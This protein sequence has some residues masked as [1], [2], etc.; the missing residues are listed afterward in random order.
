M[1]YGMEKKPNH[2]IKAEALYKQLTTNRQPY[3]DRARDASLV[4][5]P[6]LYPPEGTNYSTTHPTPYQSLG[7]KGVNNMANKNVQTLFPPS[8]AFFKLGIGKKKQA[9]LQKSEGDIKTAMYTLESSIV[10]D[11]ETSGLRPKLVHALK[12]LIVGGNV[13][14]YVPKKGR[15]EVFRLDEFG[16][17]RDKQGNVLRLAIQQKVAYQSLSKKVQS[18]LPKEKITDKVRKGEEKLDLYTCVIKQDSEMY[19]V[20]QEMCYVTLSGTE[21]TFNK[22]DLPYRFIP[23]V[24]TGEDYARSFVEDYQGDL[25]AYEG[26]RQSLLEASAESAKIIYIVKPN[27]TLSLK[28]LKD[29]RTGAVLQG[30]PED[31]TALQVDKRMD[32]MTAQTEAE[33]LRGELATIFL[34]DSAV[35]RDAERVTAE[36]I[37]QISR[38]LETAQGGIYSTLSD[39]LQNPLVRLYLNRAVANGTIPRVLKDAL[40][41]QITTGS[42]ALGRGS[43][44][45]TLQ[46]FTAF[47]Q[48]NVGFEVAQSYI[49]VD[50]LIKRAAYSLDLDTASLVKSEEERQVEQENAQAAQL[51]QAAAPEVAKATMNPSQQQE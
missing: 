16:V 8:T 23:F 32:M 9:Q 28:Q 20:W 30:N 24:D 37:R 46:T 39:N 35:R 44:F 38:E 34:L 3:L 5:I 31:V 19:Y 13:V 51:M 11:M 12:L 27:S 15:P 26:L 6:S 41:L 49:K 25:N 50:E 47:V 21:G 29:A 36:E 7:A 18:Q 33:S 45:N 4:T 48:N 40:D 10:G 2:D 22:E 42:A 17:Q 43:E 14:L 1:N